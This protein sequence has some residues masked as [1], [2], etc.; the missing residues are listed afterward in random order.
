M[1]DEL[2]KEWD[3]SGT[4]MGNAEWA[5]FETPAPNLTGLL[6]K[7]KL[8]APRSLSFD[9]DIA[10]GFI[11]DVER[12]GGR[13]VTRQ[14]PDRAAWDQALRD[15][16]DAHER[17]NVAIDTYSAA[18]QAQIDNPS[19][20]ALAIEESAYAEEGRL[21]TLD[22]QAMIRLV[23]TPAPDIEA[24]LLKLEMTAEWQLIGMP[25]IEKSI[26]ELR[27][28]VSWDGRSEQAR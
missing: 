25:P 13:A 8:I 17:W 12:F 22:S 21:S 16:R 2:E 11:G 3:D 15:Y 1:T 6:W 28:L 4:R 7:M 20:D 24:V 5:L 14:A 9:D 26:A 27:T 10:A 19:P 23:E 18:E